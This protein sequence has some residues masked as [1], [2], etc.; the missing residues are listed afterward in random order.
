MQA[1]YIALK[2]ALVSIFQ[3]T[4]EINK[5]NFAAEDTMFAFGAVVIFKVGASSNLHRLE[6]E[7]YPSSN[8]TMGIG[9]KGQSSFHNS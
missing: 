5:F 2:T 7:S 4:D 8:L 9:P 3:L 1:S 6:S